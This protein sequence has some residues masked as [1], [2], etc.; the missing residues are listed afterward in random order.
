M[1]EDHARN[2]IYCGSAACLSKCKNSV[3]LNEKGESGDSDKG[4]PLVKSDR[5]LEASFTVAIINSNGA[6]TKID[7]KDEKTIKQ[8]CKRLSCV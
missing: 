3:K 7:R 2:S 1:E 4:H 8:N 5:L 6:T